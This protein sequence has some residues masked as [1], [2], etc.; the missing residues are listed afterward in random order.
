MHFVT[1][2]G[3]IAFHLKYYYYFTVVIKTFEPP[4]DKTNTMAVYRPGSV[5]KPNFHSAML[6]IKCT[7]KRCWDFYVLERIDLVV[8]GGGFVV[9]GGKMGDQRTYFMDF[10]F[11]VSSRLSAGFDCS[12][13]WP[14]C[15]TFHMLV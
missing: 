11:V 10:L 7:N 14:F 2:Q 1:L 6:V 12:T 3:S 5:A 4:H 13:P 15:L 8:G 9:W